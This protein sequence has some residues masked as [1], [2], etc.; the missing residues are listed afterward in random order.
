MEEEL[1]AM[2]AARAGEKLAE[3][4]ADPLLRLC[5][6]INGW[7]E[8]RKNTRKYDLSWETTALAFG[9]QFFIYKGGYAIAETYWIVS[10]LDSIVLLDSWSM[11]SISMGY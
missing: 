2:K 5:E 8:I 9:L 4:D 3:R 10:M 6:K 1:K 7:P 11:M